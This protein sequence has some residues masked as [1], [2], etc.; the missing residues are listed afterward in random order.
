MR[1]SCASCASMF[2]LR[3]RVQLC[4][5]NDYSYVEDEPNGTY[6]PILPMGVLASVP[7]SGVEPPT[8]LR[9]LPKAPPPA[10]AA[11]AAA[12]AASSTERESSTEGKKVTMAPSVDERA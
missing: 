10:A 3:V 4:V 5:E 7:G 6:S 9:R 12:D 11:P 8:P 2:A 1:L